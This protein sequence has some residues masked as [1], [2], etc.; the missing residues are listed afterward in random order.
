VLEE[1]LLHL[2]SLI[3]MLFLVLPGFLYYTR[4]SGVPAAFRNIA[5]WIILGI[6]VVLLYPLYLA[7]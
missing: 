3:M 5:L 4:K 1:N 6:I 2:I 7:S